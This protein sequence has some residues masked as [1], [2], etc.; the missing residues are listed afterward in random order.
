MR[1]PIPVIFVAGNQEDW[2]YLAAY[3]QRPVVIQAGRPLH[4]GGTLSWADRGNTRPSSGRRCGALGGTITS[5]QTQTENC[6]RDDDKRH[7]S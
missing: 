5:H 3:T 1:A 2:P 6:A 7:P 4:L